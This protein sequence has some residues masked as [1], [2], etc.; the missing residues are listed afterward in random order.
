M[1]SNLKELARMENISMEFP[2][3]K[4]L[5]GV[6]FNVLEGEIHALVG[7]NGAGKSTL[8][9]I[10]MGV[11]TPSS[12]TLYINGNKANYHGP[13]D[14]IAQGLGA[15]YQD[16]TLAAHLTVGE[17][18]FLGHLPTKGGRVDWN[19]IFKDSQATL[20]DLKINIDSHT[21]VR[22]PVSYTHLTLPT[23]A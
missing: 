23:K 5:D 2:G 1:G 12:G 10:L 6:S 3:V 15:V 7:E 22:D 8:I 14:A 9:K 20:D 13:A 18:F 16:I 17:N 11:Y 19:R 4:A 21:L